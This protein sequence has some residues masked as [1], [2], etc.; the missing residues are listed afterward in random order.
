MRNWEIDGFDFASTL[1]ANL[2]LSAPFLNAGI[3]N[4]YSII[5]ETDIPREVQLK[6]LASHI[7][8]NVKTNIQRIEETN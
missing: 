8:L 7:V 3:I 4:I 5:E 6:M 2:N 1:S